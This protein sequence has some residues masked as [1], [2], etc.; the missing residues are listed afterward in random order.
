MTWDS[1]NF[2]KLPLFIPKEQAS[3]TIS[4]WMFSEVDVGD[5]GRRRE[6]GGS[7]ADGVVF[8]LLRPNLFK[9]TLSHE[10][11]LPIGRL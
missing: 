3:S 2:L 5:D 1:A 9:Q 11:V 7:V 6:V 4:S 10:R 8:L